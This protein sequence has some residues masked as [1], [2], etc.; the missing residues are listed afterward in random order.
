MFYL[1]ESLDVQLDQQDLIANQQGSE[2]FSRKY[3]ASVIDQVIDGYGIPHNLLAAAHRY[4]TEARERQGHIALINAVQGQEATLRMGLRSEV[5][6]LFSNMPAQLNAVSLRMLLDRFMYQMCHI[7][8]PKVS[9]GQKKKWRDVGSQIW[10]YTAEDMYR[11]DAPELYRYMALMIHERWCAALAIHEQNIAA[12]AKQYEFLC[13]LPSEHLEHE[14]QQ[15]GPFARLVVQSFKEPGD[16]L[17][18][19]HE[20]VRPHRQLER[21]AQFPPHLRDGNR[22][23]ALASAQYRASRSFEPALAFLGGNTVVKRL[24]ATKPFDPQNVFSLSDNDVC[25]ISWGLQYMHQKHHVWGWIEPTDI[26]FLSSGQMALKPG[27]YCY[28]EKIGPSV[29]RALDVF[30]LIWSLVSK[31]DD[32]KLRGEIIEQ[33]LLHYPDQTMYLHLYQLC[34]N[35]YQDISLISLILSAQ[36]DIRILRQM[37]II[38]KKLLAR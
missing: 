35:K 17:V 18:V 38:I 19:D 25:S 12:Y 20:S 23:L 1:H 32:S 14:I 16:E 10:S 5:R 28:Q 31:T 9:L 2:C 3:L 13:R 7:A 21:M 22:F 24:V 29:A 11:A 27:K 37:R 4:R 15:V 6:I 8:A 30:S 33:L 34:D 36:G 26:V